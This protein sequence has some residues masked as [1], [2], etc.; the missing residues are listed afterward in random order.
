MNSSIP[1]IENIMKAA[2]G[3]P[4]T[5]RIYNT[6]P[7]KHN[8]VSFDEFEGPTDPNEHLLQFNNVVFSTPILTEIIDEMMCKLFI[9][10]LKGSAIRW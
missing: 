9:R 2:K 4:L 3:T 6:V 1:A 7:P 5:D 10:S 8:S